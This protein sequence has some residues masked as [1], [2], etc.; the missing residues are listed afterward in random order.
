MSRNDRRK[1]SRAKWAAMDREQSMSCSPEM[2][3]YL[4][5]LLH[6]GP[7][8]SD[9]KRMMLTARPEVVRLRVPDTYTGDMYEV[10][11]DH[12]ATMKERVRKSIVDARPARTRRVPEYVARGSR[13]RV[14][15]PALRPTPAHLRPVP[16]PK[17]D[18]RWRVNWVDATGEVF[19]IE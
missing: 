2:G 7:R 14:L 11:S 9:E 6:Q 10:V 16:E 4:A 3:A 1:A 18:R 13:V 5:H 19:A 8:T 12:G 17:H 15:Q